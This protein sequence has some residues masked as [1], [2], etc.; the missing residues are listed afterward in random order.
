MERVDGGGFVE[1]NRD[2]PGSTKMYR[3]GKVTV[4]LFM[5]SPMLPLGYRTASRRPFVIREELLVFESP[6]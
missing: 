6:L 5:A 2:G 3:Y 4:A 1:P